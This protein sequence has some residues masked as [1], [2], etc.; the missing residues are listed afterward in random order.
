MLIIR[1]IA[2]LQLSVL[3]YN[4]ISWTIIALFA[5]YVGITFT[6]QMGSLT[7]EFMQ[8]LVFGPYTSRLTSRDFNGGYVSKIVDLL[9]LFIPLIGMGLMS[10]ELYSG[11][12]KLLYSSPIKRSSIILGKFLAMIVF[13][14]ALYLIYILSII[15][16]SLF[17]DNIDWGIIFSSS[18]A[19][20]ALIFTYSA[21]T[22]FV[23]TLTRYQIIAALISIALIFSLNYIGKLG[24]AD[25]MLSAIMPFFSLE[26]HTINLLKGFFVSS[27]IIYF[28]A[29]S[30]LFIFLAIISLSYTKSTKSEKRVLLLRTTLALVAYVAISII[31]S[32][33]NFKSY[34]D[35]TANKSHT[36]SKEYV[37][38][39]KQ[40]NDGDFTVQVYADV[41]ANSSLQPSRRKTIYAEA[42][43]FY[44]YLPNTKLEIKPFY[45]LQGGLNRFSEERKKWPLEKQ[46]DIIMK[47]YKFPENPEDIPH[48]DKLSTEEQE[49]IHAHS[50][51][52]SGNVAFKYKDKI[53]RVWGNARFDNLMRRMPEDYAN[54]VKQLLVDPIS[55]TMI[56]GNGEKD[57]NRRFPE[58]WSLVMQNTYLRECVR[59]RGFE[60]NQTDINT[61]DIPSTAEMVLIAEPTMPYDEVATNKIIGYLKAGGDLIIAVSPTNSKNIAEILN[62][63]EIEL[64]E[65]TSKPAGG[66]TTAA[67]KVAE[68]ASET[69]NHFFPT[70][71]PLSDNAKIIYK[72]S[73]FKPLKGYDYINP[74]NS[75]YSGE[76]K[77]MNI[78]AALERDVNGKT[79][80]VAIFADPNSL[81]NLNFPESL[82]YKQ[83]ASTQILHGILNWA[84]EGRY[85]MIMTS[86][87]AKDVTLSSS[88]EREKL[89]KLIY[90]G[91]IPAILILIGVW[92]AVSR[93]KK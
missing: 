36:L 30:A 92:I 38:L 46:K 63:L 88:Y 6:T 35:L 74:E 20:L 1:K 17:V 84:S 76:G 4:P 44:R 13:C 65:Q 55:L 52:P 47:Y 11:T 39:I 8:N 48:I 32:Q 69:F 59:N 18:I 60:V 62:Y 71:F 85:P 33:E 7:Q 42:N 5:I 87:E 27:D 31:S 54:A 16:A 19:I 25:P 89:Y 24:K 72:G 67:Y 82:T 78:L 49:W 37:A 61:S 81:N 3:F 14:L 75:I 21:I 2:K 26:S 51:M 12:I 93:R 41:V 9:Y 58:D 53:A 66:R 80:Q 91:I 57:I 86:V 79:Q 10:S 70:P 73:S 64:I 90:I 56:S 40:L 45:G 83:P 28:I 77:D 43:D 23:S 15:G 22:L 68:G 34:N 50:P 29:T